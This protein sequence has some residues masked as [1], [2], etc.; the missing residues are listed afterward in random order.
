MRK[1]RSLLGAGVAV[2]TLLVGSGGPADAVGARVPVSAH[3]GP[4]VVPGVPLTVCVGSECVTTGPATT[5]Q[6]DVRAAVGVRVGTLPTILPG[7]C[8][9]GHTGAVLDVSTGSSRVV[10]RGLVTVTVNGDPLTL[11]V[12][13]VK[14]GPNSTVAISACTG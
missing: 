9:L 8:P 7:L 4:V 2:A 11:P 1:L 13:P 3:V 12:G 5:V 10:I 14:L 6:L